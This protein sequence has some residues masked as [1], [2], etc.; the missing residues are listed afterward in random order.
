M[1]NTK[2]CNVNNNNDGKNNAANP[3]P[4]L[5]HVLVMQAQ[6]LQTMQHI[7]INMQQNQPAPQQGRAWRFPENQRAPQ[8]KISHGK[9]N[10]T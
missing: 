4:T 6:I 5:E 8:P 1:A 7:M 10:I 9:E 2:N 3:P